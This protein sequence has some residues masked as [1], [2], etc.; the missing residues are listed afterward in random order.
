MT[1]QFNIE[2][3]FFKLIPQ[4]FMY[5]YFSQLKDFCFPVLLLVFQFVS[6]QSNTITVNTFSEEHINFGAEN[7][8]VVTET[9]TFPDDNIS[10]SQ[11]LMHFTL[12]CP[13]GGC[14]PWDRYGDI[15]VIHPTGMMD[16]TI[17]EIDTIFDA[18]GNILQIDTLFNPPFEIT[19]AFE[20]FRFIT[21]Y[22]GSFGA[23][24]SWLWTT[25][26]TDYRILLANQVTLQAYIDTWVNPGWEVSISFEMIEG[27]PEIEAYKIVNLW[28]YGYLSYGNVNSPIENYLPPIGLNADYDAHLAKVRIYQTGHGFGFSDNAAE[29][30]PKT[31]HLLVNGTAEQ[32]FPNFLWRDDCALNPL[33]PQ[34]G[35]WQYNRAGWCPGD[36]ATPFDADISFLIEAGAPFTL[37][38]NMQPFINLCSPNNPNCTSADC[39]GGTCTG[40]GEPYYILSSQLIYYRATPQFVLDAQLVNLNGLPDISCQ[41]EFSPSVR[42][43]NNGSEVLTDVV[44]LYRLDEG[45]FQSVIWN[46]SLDFAQS[47]AIEFPGIT[48]YD[49]QNHTFEVLIA[50]A[51]SG[52]D[53][54]INNDL[55]LKSFAYGNNQLT[56]MLQTD[57]YGSETSWEIVN[58]TNG[59][60]L[61][62]GNGF[63]SL[64]TYEEAICIPNGCYQLI[65]KDSYGDGLQAPTNGNYQ[66]LD[67]AGTVLA[68][69]QQVN[70]GL[71]EVTDFCVDS[72]LPFPVSVHE[73]ISK[74]VS[75]R[76]FPN[77]VKDSTAQLLIEFTDPQSALLSV[78]H[79]SGKEVYHNILPTSD[80]HQVSLPL[81][82]FPVGLYFIQVNSDQATATGCLV[83]W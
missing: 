45:E 78:Y 30:S 26:V 11:I 77:P 33:S 6:G 37:D 15:K 43:R 8:R 65:V 18:T 5:N 25:D 54:N 82:D 1:Y 64:T 34:A 3:N 16:S 63:A 27:T 13:S 59:S 31:H 61:Q 21:P 69:L 2:V 81:S 66:L 22:G 9:F 24:W 40:G 80:S 10:F 75:I 56:L 7:K 14:D 73:T 53:E 42:L 55:L 62:S 28:N 20:I 70:F 52:L 83:K 46:G 4:K 58:P 71:Q 50:V 38:Y 47:E 19:E 67:N 48:L 29:F 35:T 79:V 76:V 60:I 36:D 44:L 68:S 49:A 51:N 57:N 41:N 72:E 17:A 23:N 39:A 32:D 74:P 12:G